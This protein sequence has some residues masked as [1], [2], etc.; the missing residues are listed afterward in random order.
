[1]SALAS[2]AVSVTVVSGHA[3]DKVEAALSG[4]EVEIVRNAD[5]ATGMAS[6][7]KAGVATLPA[8]VD[9]V[10]VMLADMPFVEERTLDRLIARFENQP[11]AIDAVVPVYEGRRGNPV[12]IGRRLFGSIKGLGGDEGARTLLLQPGLAVHFFEVN[13]PGVTIDVDTLPELEAFNQGG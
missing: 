9:G 10:L 3:R 11:V 2:R 4:L 7:L 8:A 12:L 13:D 1:M 6:S 5:F